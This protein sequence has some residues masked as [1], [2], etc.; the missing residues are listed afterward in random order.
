MISLDETCENDVLMMMLIYITVYKNLMI[1][2][3]C[4]FKIEYE[5]EI[6]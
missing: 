4:C 6:L 1:N 3:S 5:H 2:N